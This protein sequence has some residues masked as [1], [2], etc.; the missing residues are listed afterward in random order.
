MDHPLNETASTSGGPCSVPGEQNGTASAETNGTAHTA[1][2]VPPG[3]QP[4]AASAEPRNRMERAEEIVDRVSS[5]VGN[6]T[7]VWGKR[8]I[9]AGSRIR[10][11][12]ED[13]WA[14]AQNIRRGD[15]S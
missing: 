13:F 4:D 2:A 10:E 8:L 5:W 14:E 15:K 9:R 1:H 3:P 7:S 12:A 6:M 11:E